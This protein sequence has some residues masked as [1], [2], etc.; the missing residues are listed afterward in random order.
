MNLTSWADRSK[1]ELQV[2]AQIASTFKSGAALQEGTVIAFSPPSLPGLGMVGGFTLMLEDRSGGSLTELDATAQKFIDAA[3]QRPE[4]GSIAS[5]FQANTPGYEFAVDREKAEKMGVSVDDVFTALQA[6]LGGT[7][8]NDFN[9]F[10][11]T[12][13]VIV[14]AETPFRSDVDAMRYLYVKN[15]TSTMV[16]LNTLITPKK[17]SAPAI[18]T[19]FNG[20]KAVKLSGNPAAG[21]SSGQA[22]SALEAVAAQTLPDGYS[23]EWSGQSR[24]EKISG[25]RAPIVFGMAILFVF[26]CLA[27]LYESWTVPFAVLL[28][29]PTTVFGAFMFMFLRGMENSVYMQIGLVM[30]IGLAAKN[31]ILIVEF[32]KVRVER[33][34]P[35]RQAAVEAAKL[36][37]RPHYHDVV[38]LHF[39]LLTANVRLRRRC[40]RAERDGHDR[41]RRH[42]AGH[43][44]GDFC[45][46]VPVRRR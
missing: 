24:E 12:Y 30:L 32:A 17:V 6:F 19:R 20:V 11:R 9:K 27:A 39:R 22:M 28:T 3:K 38:C 33:G 45:Y 31:A 10:G 14:Q 7:Q 43:N 42:D 23:Y 8:V 35:I 40:W 29:V 1:T 15:S 13:K 37:M 5:N 46:S 36:R 44:A 34:M 2:A 21:Y 16:P 41:G 26:L 18:I 25:N 4:I